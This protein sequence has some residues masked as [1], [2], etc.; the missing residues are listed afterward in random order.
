MVSPAAF[1]FQFVLIQEF[2]SHD[3]VFPTQCYG[4]D[5]PRW[6]KMVV[7]LLT[8]LVSGA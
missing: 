3:V 2:A 7:T 1:E 6:G 5:S 4:M 8:N